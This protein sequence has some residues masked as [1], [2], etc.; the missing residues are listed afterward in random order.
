[1][2]DVEAKHAALREEDEDQVLAQEMEEEEKEKV[3][4]DAETKLGALVAD[5]SAKGGKWDVTGEWKIR[6]PKFHDED[7]WSDNKMTLRMYRVNGTKVSQMFAK[8]DFSAIKGWFR[9]EDPATQNVPDVSVR[10]KRKQRAW[11]SFLIPLDIKP[12]PEY[13]TWNYRW[14]GEWD[15][16][17]IEHYSDEYQYSIA[18]SGKGGCTLSGT[19]RTDFLEYGFEGTKLGMIDPAEASK[20]AIDDQW[21]CLYDSQYLGSP[22]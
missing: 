6:C 10:Q 12:S 18:F 13:P 4:R 7:Y 14:R 5:Q 1:M 20:I 22:K 21:A 15:E 17:Y 2:A 11:D 9:F 16:G 3:A 8:F 19:F